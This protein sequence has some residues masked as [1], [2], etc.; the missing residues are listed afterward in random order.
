MRRAIKN[1]KILS[2]KLGPEDHGIFSAYVH[3]KYGAGQQGFGG[4]DLRVGGSAYQFIDR[5]LRAAGVNC[6]EKLPGTHVRVDAE[7][8]KV[9]SIGHIIDDDKWFDPKEM[10][11]EESDEDGS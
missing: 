10:Y 3:L 4:Y 9:H 8:S 2:T 5:V 7:H 6:W 1:A 11:E